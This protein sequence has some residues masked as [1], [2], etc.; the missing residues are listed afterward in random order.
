MLEA[1]KFALL[2]PRAAWPA[3]EWITPE[4][5]LNMA[6]RGARIAVGQPADLIA[7]DAGASAFVGA[8]RDLASRIVLAAQPTDLV[9]VMGNGAFLMRD[10]A[11]YLQ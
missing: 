5:V 6:T 2:A 1:A 3:S 4:Q 8:E 7:F 10:R 11:M 9:H